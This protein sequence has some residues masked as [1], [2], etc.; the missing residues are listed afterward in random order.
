VPRRFLRFIAEGKNV[1]SSSDPSGFCDL[2][3]KTMQALHRARGRRSVEGVS[4]PTALMFDGSSIRG[5][6]QIHESDMQ[7]CSPTCST[8]VLDPFRTHKDPEPH[9]L[10]CHD[11][12]NRR[13]VY[14][15]DPAQHRPPRP[16]NYLAAVTGISADT[17]FL[18]TGG[19]SFYILRLG[20]LLHLGERGLLPHRF[21]RRPPGTPV[22]EGERF[23]TSPTS[24]G[25]RAATSRSPPDGPLHPDPAA[26]RWSAKT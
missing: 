17:A 4:S 26:R 14:S 3:G 22:D 1:W 21:S 10:P 2:A 25:T 5:F 19:G 9:L 20:A 11:P 23:T 6:Q 7:L 16:R 15:R 13:A 8:A 24:P 12:L 18:R